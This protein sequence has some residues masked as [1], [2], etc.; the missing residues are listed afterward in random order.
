MYALFEETEM[1]D[2]ER[3]REV[4]KA[5][6]EII[7]HKKLT[8]GKIWIYFA[9][10]EIRQRNLGDARKIF[11]A[12]IGKC[13]KDKLFREYIELELQLREF[14]RCRKLYEKERLKYHLKLA[15]LNYFDH[16]RVF[17]GL[18]NPGG[19][20]WPALKTMATRHAAPKNPD[21]TKITII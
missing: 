13:P 16:F 12:A 9:Q 2:I 20:I 4:W 7:P 17:L 19:I 8:F 5:C 21:K 15:V 3:T 1:A 10:F 6:L 14:D 11:G 18:K